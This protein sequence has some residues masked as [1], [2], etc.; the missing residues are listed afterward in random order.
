MPATRPAVVA[1]AV[2]AVGRKHPVEAR[3]A[4]PRLRHQIRQPGDKVEGF[5]D[6]VTKR[7]NQD[8]ISAPVRNAPGLA[9]ATTGD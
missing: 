3:E 2:L 7:V 1:A 5:E 8:A 4:D 9:F 6:D